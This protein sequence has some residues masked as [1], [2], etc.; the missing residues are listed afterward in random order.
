MDKLTGHEASVLA[1]VARFPYSLEAREHAAK[2]TGPAYDIAWQIIEPKPVDP[3]TNSESVV[4]SA[5]GIVKWAE[6]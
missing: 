6:G 5:A 4:S 1:F 2:L 3:I